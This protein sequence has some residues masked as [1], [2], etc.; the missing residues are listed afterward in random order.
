VRIRQFGFLANRARG[1]KLALCRALL[2][3]PE[4]PPIRDAEDGVG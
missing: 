2:D 3:A 4:A 1:I